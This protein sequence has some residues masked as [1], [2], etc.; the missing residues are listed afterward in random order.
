MCLKFPDFEAGRAYE[1]GAYKKNVYYSIRWKV[2]TWQ[3]STIT[4]GPRWM[5]ILLYLTVK[6]AHAHR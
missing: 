1:L 6:R 3:P 5:H 4:R 2:D